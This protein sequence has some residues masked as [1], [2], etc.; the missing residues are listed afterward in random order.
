MK[1]VQGIFFQITLSCTK[2]EDDEKVVCCLYSWNMLLSLLIQKLHDRIKR[3]QIN[4]YASRQ[5]RICNF[6]VSRYFS[7]NSVLE[8]MICARV[9]LTKV[10]I[11]SVSIEKYNFCEFVLPTLA[12]RT[13]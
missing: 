11:G 1:D 8:T 10:G 3:V 7:I 6:P 2:V 5:I 13:P 4:D 9:C 12:D